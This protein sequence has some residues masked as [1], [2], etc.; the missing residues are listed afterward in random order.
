MRE[1]IQDIRYAFRG[2]RQSRG[3]TTVAV[4]TLGLG[5]GANTAI[6][7]V[8]NSVLLRPLGYPDPDRLVT[9]EHHYPTLGDLHASVSV[10]GFLAYQQKRQ[11][12]EKAA[13]QNGWQPT[14]TGRGEPTRV[15]GSQVSGDFFGVF[16]V[17]PAL[18][19]VLGAEEAE[20]G[21]DRVVV[22]SL[23]MWQRVFGEDPSALGQRVLLDGESYEIVG[24]MPPAFVDFWNRRAEFWVPLAF[25]PAQMDPNRWTNEFLRFTARIRSGESVEQASADLAAYGVQLRTEN[26]DRFS[27]DWGLLTTTLNEKARGP[28]RGA[29][30]LM[31]GAVGLVL[32]IA[33]ANVANLQLARAAARG[34]EIA[35]RVALGASP[36]ALMRQ[37]LTE[38]ILLALAGG[39]LGVVLAVWSV[40]ALLAL[41]G[42]RGLPDASDVHLDG[43]VLAF[44]LLI[45]VLTGIVFG[46]APAIRV[47]RASLNEALKEGGRG[48]AADR[49]GL[50]LRRSLVVA[51]V[52]LALML[53][54]GSGLLVRSFGRLVGMDP[55]FHSDHLLTFNV[56]LP[57][58]KYPND[59]VR[60]AALERIT[61]A[62][63]NMP[64]VT[65]AGGTSVMPFGGSWSTGSFSVEG[66]QPPTNAPGPW[67]DMRTVTPDFLPTLGVELLQGRQFNG[68][69]RAGGRAVVIVDEEMARRFWPNE[70]PVGKR[71][72]FNN[73]TD[74]SIAW[75]DVVG[76]VRHTMHEGLDAQARVQLYFPLQQNALPF[77]AYAVRVSGDPKAIASLVRQAVASVD[78][79]LPVS[80][81]STMDELIEGTTGPRRFAMLLLGSFS[82]LAAAL[83]AIGLYGVMSY[84]VTQRSRE[85]GVRLALGAV[86]RDVLKLVLGQG[87]RLAL[88]GV[89]VG[90]VAALVLTRLLRSMLF[91][92]SATDPLTFVLIPLLLLAVTLL[93]SWIPARRA[94]RVDPAV[95]LRAD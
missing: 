43:S 13:V 76:E 72:T 86:Q 34:R 49:G 57:Q 5:I 88:I 10:P 90:L 51:T 23:G 82:V 78:A 61:S 73:L 20:A 29:L 52:A 85:L 7:S 31:L 95:V 36:G 24:I 68:E 47:A 46:L 83:A 54:A 37:L 1:L 39:V 56:A 16:G 50:A 84:T 11:I 71:I 60:I 35:V 30:Y 18:G 53:L 58:V 70:N 69:D 87:L 63:S 12:F 6:F 41:G 65:S 93:A 25:T 32:L 81:V 66:F 55:G 94:T 38:S 79:D 59:T 22:L 9:V 80:N 33:C 26:P 15:L 45:S 48:V 64:G 62:L 40:P 44:A 74:S 89:G 75:V 21:H 27:P 19:R 67:G 8:I 3:F 14:L 91:N 42:G 2:L 28:M 17:P 4:L 92:V 77:L